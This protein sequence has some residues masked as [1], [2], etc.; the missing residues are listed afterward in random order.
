MRRL[1]K[2][3][4]QCP[5]IGNVSIIPAISRSPSSGLTS[6][7]GAAGARA[8]K[9]SQRGPLSRRWDPTTPMI[10]SSPA[11]PEQSTTF[12]VKP[13]CCIHVARSHLRAMVL[14][15]P[16]PRM[17][18][19]TSMLL[20]STSPARLY[21]WRSSA[22]TSVREMLSTGSLNPTVPGSARHSCCLRQPFLLPFAQIQPTHSAKPVDGPKR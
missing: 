3:C 12:R 22:N 16:S 4:C 11:V 21:S 7:R 8:A 2:G 20:T 15:S 10:R 17:S 13:M 6:S 14:F 1:Q 19:G 9:K 18:T 5:I